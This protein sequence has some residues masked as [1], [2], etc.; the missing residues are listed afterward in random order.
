MLEPKDVFI[1]GKLP[2]SQTN[3]YAPRTREK[4]QERFIKALSRGHVPL[5]FG[6]YGVGKTSMARHVVRI[7]EDKG[8]LV[9]IE[10]VA[11]KS[12]QDI[13]GRCLEKLGYAV[14]TKRVTGSSSLN[15]HEQSAQAKAGL[16]WLESIIASKRTKTEGSTI[17]N[18][19]Q[20][21]V[22]SPTD[23]KL[24]EL[25][26]A[27]GLVLILDELHRAK[28]EFTQELA[29]FI[30]TYGNAN[31][32]KFRIILL[33]TSSEANKLVQIDP[34]IDRLIQEVHLRAMDDS[35]ARYV[36]SEG[37][38]S[39][40]ITI[41]HEIESRL[42]SICVGSPNILQYLCLEAAEAAFVRV[43]R[44]LQMQDVDNALKE[45][46]E[47]REA[48]LYRAYLSAIETVGEK[49]Y[50]KQ[51]LRAM[52]E[53]EDEYVTMEN[54]RSLSSQYIGEDVPS[55]ALSGPLRD[56]KEKKFGPLLQDV[57]RPDQ[58]GRLSNYTVFVDPSMK[59][60]IRL[61]AASEGTV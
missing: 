58:S 29:D 54:I 49:R 55:T 35:E 56:L 61:L 32:R 33:G 4:A 19:E 46:V 28:P 5:I 39:L 51:I 14:Q 40:A 60:F 20:F 9:N 45:Y 59:A 8:V 41:D 42:T 16:P 47:N 7:D 43:P 26:E 21:V 52:A 24:I 27:A 22:T 6:E 38:K 17:Q 25:C 36:V 10:S 18:E 15:A 31:C 12:L 48:R 53:C 13:F 37:M 3:I 11:G 23:S 34:G 2:L 30:K 44:E 50:R 1:P 57:D